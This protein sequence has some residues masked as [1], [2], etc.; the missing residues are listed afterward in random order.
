[1]EVT[2]AKLAANRAN[3]KKS[4][5]PRTGKGKQAVGRNGVTHGLFCRDVVLPGEDEAEF[6]QLR[7]E[8]FDAIVPRNILERMLVD[9]IVVANWQLARLNT[10]QKYTVDQRTESRRE[11]DDNWT[12]KT[13]LHASLDYLAEENE[14]ITRHQQRLERSIYR[15]MKELRELRKESQSAEVRE[16]QAEQAESTEPGE[17]VEQVEQVEQIE[18]SKAKA[19]SSDT[20]Q[21]IVG[22]GDAIEA[23]PPSCQS[24]ISPSPSI[25]GAGY[26][27]AGGGEGLSYRLTS[28]D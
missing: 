19:D 27:L 13:L 25:L 7:E 5:G 4:T 14:K 10:M 9:R 15:A 23:A 1:M 17:R 21:V 24:C 18:E 22:N 8:F 26:P 11:Y 16:G 6:Q 28:D 12:E 3:S 20:T 2:P